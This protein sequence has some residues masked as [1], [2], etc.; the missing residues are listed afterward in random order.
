MTADLVV[1][2]NNLLPVVVMIAR[3]AVGPV[4]LTGV[5]AKFRLINVFDGTVAIDDADASTADAVNFTASGATI[6]ATGHPF[7]NDESVT[8]KTT[9]ILPGN[10]TTQ[11][12]YFIVNATANSLQLSL[13]PGG[14]PITTSNAGSG[15]HSLLSGR[16]TYEWQAGDTAKPGT[17]FAEIRATQSGLPITY[18]NTRQLVIEINSD[19][20]GNAERT[21]A[22]RAV[23]DRVQP[24]VEPTLSQGEI[25]LEVD[26]AR[27]VTV[28]Q[29][30]T[31]YKIG[32][33]IVPAV[34][35]G[36]CYQCIQPGTSKAG[37]YLY[38]D[39]PQSF[40]WTFGDGNTDPQLLWE[41][42]GHDRFNGLIAGAETNIYDIGKAAQQCWLI[43][44]RKV[45]EFVDEGDTADEQLY[46]H[47]MEQAAL[48][49]PFSRPARVV[50]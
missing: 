47:C 20:T 7:N 43:K 46:K 42:C 33:V 24:G 19:L 50:V 12:E 17:Y 5:T 44:A 39:W 18:P 14:T 45:S 11:Y 38:T 26:R 41:E 32:D 27:L 48:F 3:D 49:R 34:R 23:M 22:I 40:G 8:L 4:D 36:H 13:I 29:P 30:N 2:A 21:V 35:N 10:L 15:V 9:G 28:W 16:V 25:E 6:N 37:S 1:K 31:A